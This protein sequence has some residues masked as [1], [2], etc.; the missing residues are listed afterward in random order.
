MMTALQSGVGIHTAQA[1]RSDRLH[2]IVMPTERCNFRCTYCYEDFAAGRMQPELVSGLKALVS[3]RAAGLRRLEIAWF[4]G[5]PLLARDIIDDVMSHVGALR[6]AHPALEIQSDITTNAWG[7]SLAV[8]TRL[9]DLGVTTYQISFDG[10]A[11]FH[12]RAR[13]RAG[14]GPTF[15]RIWGHVRALRAV[16]RPFRI[17]LRVHADQRN[18]AAI[19]RFIDQV[20]A[21]F[22]SDLRFVLFI[23]GLG[24]FGGANDAHLPILAEHERE[25][26]LAAL[27]AYARAS[28][29]PT[30][31]PAAEASMCYAAR[32]NSFVV[33][34][35]G[36]LNKCT[37]SLEHPAN[38]VGRLLPDGTVSV[39]GA[40]VQPWLRGL[41]SGDA[42]ELACPMKGLAETHPAS[43]ELRIPI[44]ATR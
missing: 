33:R 14:G 2:L 40:A 15:E 23:R 20:A 5:E 4:G 7:L 35:D 16:D 29:V 6:E 26:T 19:P 22:K 8:F 12:D 32:G 43:S 44:Q 31:E 17:I 24:R 25:A 13:V 9:L 11:E 38:Q 21:E 36:R 1:L 30:Y 3:R 39:D 34:A 28:G 18:V 42:G 10:P 37:L 41:L 27:R